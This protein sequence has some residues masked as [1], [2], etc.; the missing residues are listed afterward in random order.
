VRRCQRQSFDLDQAA[1]D[2]STVTPWL[3]AM[4]PALLARFESSLCPQ[5]DQ[6]AADYDD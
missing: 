6:H 3:F 5:H 4:K 1:A 2:D